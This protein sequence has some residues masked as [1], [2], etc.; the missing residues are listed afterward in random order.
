MNV[1]KLRFKAFSGE[2]HNLRL[3][4]LVKSLD[5]G[6]SVNGEDVGVN[7]DEFSVLKTSCVSL[8]IFNPSERKRVILDKEILRLKEPL[9]DNSLVM[10]RSNTPLLVGSSAFIYKAPKN[11]YLSDKLWQFKVNDNVDIKWLALHLGY[12]VTLI[13]LRDMATGTS[14]SMKNITKPDVLNLELA[15]PSKQEQ[16]KIASFLTAIDERIAQLTQKHT[17][18]NQYKKG[19]MQQ[20]FSQ[21]LRFKDENGEDFADWEERSLN[22]ISKIIM[23]SSPKSE[24]YNT[25]KNGIPLIQG[26]ADIKN[27]KSAPRI[28]SSHIT[29]EC[30]PNDIL[31]SVRAPVG[32]V[33][34]SMHHAC[35]GRGIAAIRANANSSQDFIYQWFLYFENKWSSLSQGSTFESVNSDEIKNLKIKMPPLPE[36]TK[37]ANFLSSIDQKIEQV[38]AQLDAT[39]QYKRGLLQQM[40]V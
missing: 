12:E 18:L 5:A 3:K 1:P 30:L 31:L 8:G 26:N 33:S 16:T 35:I 24:F 4:D 13:K 38:A 6:V 25:I 15:V 7:N 9:L 20:I 22:S 28:F 27:R 34:I 17:L 14:N 40:F 37:I 2:W 19:M 21:Q 10:N 36:Q 32:E 39:K 11:T 29:R 23:G